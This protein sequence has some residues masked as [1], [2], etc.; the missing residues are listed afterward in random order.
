MENL[1]ES[2]GESTKYEQCIKDCLECYHICTR[3]LHHCIKQG[4]E[5]VE[6][7]HLGLLIE[8]SRICQLSSEL[9][10]SGSSFSDEFCQICARACDACAESC[11]SID[12]QDQMMQECAQTCTRCAA[13]CRNMGH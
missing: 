10:L 8:C 4:G 11:L 9:M 6:S 7:K 2:R 1:Q 5:H 13:S 12:P 3:T